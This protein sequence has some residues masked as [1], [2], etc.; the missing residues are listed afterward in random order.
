MAALERRCPEA[1]GRKCLGEQ[2]CGE[3]CE[4]DGI[5]WCPGMPKHGRPPRQMREARAVRKP[6]SWPPMLGPAQD[7]LREI[8][9][10]GVMTSFTCAPR[11]RSTGRRGRCA[12]TRRGLA[13]SGASTRPPSTRR[14]FRSRAG[15]TRGT[16]RSHSK[17]QIL[18]HQ[19]VSSSVTVGAFLASVLRQS[20]RLRFWRRPIT[21]IG[22][23]PR[24]LAVCAIHA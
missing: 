24:S 8:G 11:V 5:N 14:P 15:G 13:A 12:R 17:S 9:A 2:P 20:R 19:F 10:K 21:T 16:S 1:H 23:R 3:E 22:A 7:R 4:L 18:F 6:S